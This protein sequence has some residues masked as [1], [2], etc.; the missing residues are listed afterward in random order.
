MA[1]IG[2]ILFLALGGVLFDKVGPGSIFLVKGIVNLAVGLYIFGVRKKINAG[3]EDL[4][5]G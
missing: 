4:S 5:T 3:P 1:Q 2:L